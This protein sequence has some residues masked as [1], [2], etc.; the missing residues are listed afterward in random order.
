MLHTL[1]KRTN[2]ITFYKNT[3]G[4]H[5]CL[6]FN[7]YFRDRRKRENTDVRNIDWLLPTLIRDL[8][9]NLGIKLQPLVDGGPSNR[10]TWP[11][12]NK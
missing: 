5:V 11:E 12:T 2:E 9:P 10:A 3:H 7:F 8:P 1:A 6:F 4:E